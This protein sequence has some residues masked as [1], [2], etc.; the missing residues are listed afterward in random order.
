[1]RMNT[2]MH[3][4]FP[5]N[6]IR[7]VACA[8]CSFVFRV[9]EVRSGGVRFLNRVRFLNVYSI[10][11]IK[12]KNL[13]FSPYFHPESKVYFISSLRSPFISTFVDF[14]V[15]INRNKYCFP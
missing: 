14:S 9:V 8:P 12:K 4:L 13:N 7:S 15:L 3:F 11:T 1:M 10:I 6:I 2:K 5:L